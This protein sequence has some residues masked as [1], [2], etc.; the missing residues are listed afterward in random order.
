M[1]HRHGKQPGPSQKLGPGPVL[2]D[3][4]GSG[5]GQRRGEELCIN[6]SGRDRENSPGPAHP[7]GSS[8]G[9]DSDCLLTVFS[10]LTQWR[11]GVCTNPSG[12][13]SSRTRSARS[14]RESHCSE[15]DVKHPSLSVK[16]PPSIVC[17][18]R[19]SGT[20]CRAKGRIA[21]PG[22]VPGR[23]SSSRSH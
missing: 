3:G 19:T 5:G 7:P 12:L 1:G 13:L 11:D 6:W 20:D 22:W 10:H 8:S 14:G 18:F 21:T 15:M 17:P 16:S 2:R 23:E 9:S 4:C